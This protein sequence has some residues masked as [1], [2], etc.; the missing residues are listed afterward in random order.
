VI[1]VATKAELRALITLAGK[2][3]PSLQAAIMK[4]T[5]MNLNLTQNTKKTANLMGSVWKI[6]KGV[7]AGNLMTKGLSI[8]SNAIKTVTSDGIELASSLAEVQNVVDTTFGESSRIIDQWAAKALEAFGLSELQ[9]KQFTGTI[10]AILKS[11]GISGQYL[12]QMSENLAALAGDFASFYNLDH[13]EAFS[14]IRSGIS[15][16]TEPLKQ[17]GINMSIANLEAFAL[18]KGIKVAYKD[19]DQA[20][21]VMLRYAYLMEKSKD[22]Q[23]D[24]AKTL[25]T[26]YA[27]QKRLLTTNFQQMMAQLASKTVPVLTKGIKMLNSYL[28]NIDAERIGIIIAE[29]AGKLFSLI[30]RYGPLI[31]DTIGNIASK[32]FGTAQMIISEV[33]PIVKELGSKLYEAFE[34]ARPT[35][36]WLINEGISVAS[37]IISE[38]FN[39][40][41]DIYNFVA[42]NWTKIEPIL[43][44]IAGALVANKIAMWG[45][46]AAEKA[47]MI[48]SALSKAW[49]VASSVL[50]MFKAGASIATVAQWG[51]NA[52]MAANPVGLLVVAI[53]ALIA[54]GVALYK[55]WDKISSGIVGIWQN[56]VVPFFNSIGAWFSNLWNGIVNGFK[57]AW[58]GITSW[59]SNLWDGIVNIF[60]GYIN[61]YINMFNFVIK[62][63]NKIQFDIPDWVPLVG[64]KHIGIN[65]PLIPTFAEGG[66]ADQPSI[67][68]EAGLEAAIP[69]KYKNPRSIAILNQTAKM[70]GAE[71]QRRPSISLSFNFYG[72]VNNKE[73]VTSAVQ[74][75]KDYILEVIDEYYEGRVRLEFG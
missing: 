64:G 28:R 13:E 65:I 69:I 23:G 37:N 45:L 15:G 61:T 35:I 39:K 71:P 16:Q 60:K 34:S 8:I 7:F 29:K 12:V 18:S 26:S 67:F 33:I 32:V 10:G 57:N 63:L 17:L 20:S 2:I 74:M 44:G 48:I 19:M 1:Y 22:A 55:N 68:G 56:Y 9:A 30:E 73:E 51:L 14:K 3:D 70:I 42:N 54:I 43:W 24:F 36:S 46:V 31:I 47:G 4:F 62:A 58:N 25:E 6:A 27:N 21:Q 41:K 5:K 52:A 40:A 49:A 75:A 72:P 38:L 66:F 59:F 11:S 53:G 50:A